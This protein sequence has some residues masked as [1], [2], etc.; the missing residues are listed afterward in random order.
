MMSMFITNSSSSSSL[1][2]GV[3][4]DYDCVLHDCTLVGPHA[5]LP[6]VRNDGLRCRISRMS[7]AFSIARL[8]PRRPEKKFG[9]ALGILCL[10]CCLATLGITA[11]TCRPKDHR[12]WY[13]MDARSCIR[14]GNGHI[15]GGLSLLSSKRVVLRATNVLTVS[16][17]SRG[18]L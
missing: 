6:V 12:P 14:S 18:W 2:N 17:D 10:M 16:F 13:M 9:V 5:I 15:I 3:L 4:L 1:H 11:V 8:F 7:L